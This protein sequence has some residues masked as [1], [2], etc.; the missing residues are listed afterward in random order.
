MEGKSIEIEELKR[1]S[2]EMLKALDRF[3][4]EHQIRYYLGGGTL[5]GA[6]RHQGYI[7]WDD[8]IDVMVPRPD[9]DKLIKTFNDYHKDYILRSVENDSTYWRPFAKIFDLRTHLEEDWLR[10]ETPGNAISIDIFPIDGI[11]NNNIRQ[12]IFFKVQE[13]L[14]LLYRGSAYSMQKSY[15]YSKSNSILL[16]IKG[17]LRS[18]AKYIFVFLMS[19]IS[20]KKMARLINWHAKR[21]SYEECNLVG[22]ITECLYGAEKETLIKND[23]EPQQLF[24]FEDGQFKG[25][26]NFDVYLRNLYG[27]YMNLPP[28]DKRVS[29]HRYR[30]WWK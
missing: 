18:L 24:S 22:A 28:E 14:V 30:A 3:C 17:E 15:K 12:K 11:P 7:P 16:R 27:E 4:N 21:Y 1:I 23:F 6:V 20:A 9:Y 13:L 5:L 26:K 25:S 2:L 10:V 19:P 8:D 29:H